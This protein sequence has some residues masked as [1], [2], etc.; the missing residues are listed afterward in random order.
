MICSDHHGDRPGRFAEHSEAAGPEPCV[1]QPGNRGFPPDSVYM[2]DVL[3]FFSILKGA[4]LFQR[5]IDQNDSKQSDCD[6]R[7]TL[8]PLFLHNYF[9]K[10]QYFENF[11]QNITTSPLKSKAFAVVSD[12]LIPQRSVD[13]NPNRTKKSSRGK[14]PQLDLV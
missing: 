5:Q 6:Q 4:A 1:D 13:R 8:P 2:N 3:Q 11:F 14:L 12:S 10:R 9:A 7:H